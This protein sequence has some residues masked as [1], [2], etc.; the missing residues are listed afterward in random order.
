M[1]LETQY[2]DDTIALSEKKINQYDAEIV[3]LRSDIKEKSAKKAS[4]PKLAALRTASGTTSFLKWGVILIGGGL[5]YGLG[6]AFIPY[7]FVPVILAVSI[8]VSAYCIG[9]IIQAVFNRYHAKGRKKNRCIDK[10][11]S[12]QQTRI[13]TLKE[14]K[15]KLSTYQV[16]LRKLA[17][18]IK[19]EHTKAPRNAKSLKIPKALFSPKKMIQLSG[20]PKLPIKN[21]P[22]SPFELRAS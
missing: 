16:I 6:V 8:I 4:K 15:E 17:C 14:N 21:K 7:P 10:E 11:I 18:C 9:S 20:K 5:S 1:P 3:I 2:L 22:A 13:E 12:T 19:K